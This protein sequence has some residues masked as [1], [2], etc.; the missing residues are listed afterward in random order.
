MRLTPY[1][2][3]RHSNPRGSQ[4]ERKIPMTVVT[5][6]PGTLLAA[7][8]LALA[9][10][11]GLM[12]PPAAADFYSDAGDEH[13]TDAGETYLGENSD[14]GGHP[15]GIVA[16]DFNGDGQD[17]LAASTK[18]LGLGPEERWRWHAGVSVVLSTPSGA[19]EDPVYYPIGALFRSSNP[20]PCC[21]LAEVG[22]SMG[23]SDVAA[24]DVNNDG[25]PDLVAANSRSDS[26]S[27]LVNTGAGIF[28]APTNWPPQRPANT[29][30]VRD[31]IEDN[32]P[33]PEALQLGGDNPVAVAAG[34]LDG[35][36]DQDLVTANQRS[37]DVS[38][39]LNTTNTP[40][41]SLH[42]GLYQ[43]GTASPYSIDGTSTTPDDLVIADL[44]GDG[45]QDVV[46][47]NHGSDDVSVLLNDGSA[48]L[49]LHANS[50]IA[51]GTDPA[52]LATARLDSDNHEDVVTA[53]SG[54]DDVS[55]LLNDGNASFAA[56]A[57]SPYAVGTAPVDVVLDD[58][59]GTDATDVATANRGSRGGSD[60]NNISVLRG[61]GTG[62]LASEAN[63]PYTVG[64]NPISL[65]FG[66]FD[67]N[68]AG[69]ID[70]DLAAAN[71]VP[72]SI[73]VLH[74]Q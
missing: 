58:L 65:A 19:Y 61:D 29:F 59:G 24:A 53:N 36:G 28:A 35:D 47:A 6:L 37:D 55:V 5:K 12:A 45:D 3:R 23:A 15:T 34:D 46:T 60:G 51:V 69:D 54:S 7:L 25:A 40:D 68:S 57:G 8:A 56:E 44:D 18:E 50:P 30:D 52:G 27:V 22:D 33:Q 74:N 66:N 17:D 38:V 1:A 63:S 48:N 21:P 64:T 2:T 20:A 43:E 11:A 9:L 16:A 32:E 42:S 14:L 41:D 70:P 62:S 71:Y 73:T 13:S 10:S 67:S 26:V 31:L 72:Q 4:S 49:A 39:L